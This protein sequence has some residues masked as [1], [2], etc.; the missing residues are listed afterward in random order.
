MAIV[1]VVK[2]DGPPHVL[3]WK[4]PSQELGTWTQVIVNEAQEALLYKGGQALDWFAAGSHTLDTK[5]IPLLSAFIR[6][7]FGGR[8]PFTA[9]V[10]YVNKVTSLDVKWGTPTPIQLQDPK[11]GV[12]IPVRSFGQFGLRVSNAKIFL[13]K[14]VGT[15]DSFSS[16]TVSKYFR[17]VYLTKAKD[18][19]AKYLVVKK[20]SVLEL[21][22]YIDDLSES[23]K[24][25]IQPTLA[26]YGLE[27]VNFQVNDLSVPDDDPSVV[28]LRDALAKRAEM[29]IIQYNYTQ[30]RSFDS[31]EGAAKNPGSGA[32]PIMGAGLGLAMGAGMGGAFGATM[33]GIA[34][35]INTNPVMT[36]PHCNRQMPSDARFCPSCGKDVT[37]ASNQAACPKCGAAAGPGMKFCAQCGTSMTRTCPKCDGEIAD[38]QKFCPHCG[39]SLVKACAKCGAELADGLKF[40]SQCG[41]ETGGESHD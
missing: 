14:L 29:D 41:Q 12:M 25:R 16:E 13:Q 2:Y 28:K 35:N 20:I 32:A 30:E 9:E 18:D 38:G 23:L 21:N 34:Q 3:A 6:L 39:Q 5:N 33:S 10:W 19:I 17:G 27:L 31:I 37:A 24:A 11:Y 36:C 26:E 22:A 1:S 15:L 7:P 4:Y 8:S 40:C